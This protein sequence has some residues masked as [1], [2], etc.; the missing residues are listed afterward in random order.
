MMGF[1]E[2]EEEVLADAI[3]L[4]SRLWSELILSQTSYL[5]M[6]SQATKSIEF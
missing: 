3:D 4:I 2:E 1:L 6:Y 5:F